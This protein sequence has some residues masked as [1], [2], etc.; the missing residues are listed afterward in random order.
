MGTQTAIEWSDATWNPWQG[1]TKVSPACA[2]CYMFQGMKR[3]G[4]DPTHV[5]QSSGE[6]WGLPIKRWKTGERAGEYKIAP[7]KKVFTCSWSDWFHEAADKWRGQAWDIIRQRPDLTFQIVTKRTERIA[8][9]L[10]SDWENG[11]PNVW[12]IATVENQEYADRRIP[13]LLR[14]PAVVRGLSIEPMLGPIDL[15]AVLRRYIDSIVGREQTSYETASSAFGDLINWVIAGGE[16]GPGAR[17]MHPAWVRLL[18]D[19]CLAAGVAFFFKQWGDYLDAEAVEALHPEDRW[20]TDRNFYRPRSYGKADPERVRFF[21]GEGVLV[22]DPYR[23]CSDP[24]RVTML[25]VGKKAAGR[26]LD[27]VEW[28]QFPEVQHA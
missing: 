4:K 20:W 21:D 17:P 8:A 26:R 7:G 10:P 24:D 12:L 23:G 18:R 6:T 13:E 16:S 27:G 15:I 25:R 2:H 14:V 9:C 5:R 1:C 28:N 11:W 19:Q 22:A 3:F